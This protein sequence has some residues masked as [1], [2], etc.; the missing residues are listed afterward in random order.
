MKSLNSVTKLRS[1]GRQELKN[2]LAGSI[3]SK[4]IK[5]P[6][7]TS[8]QFKVFNDGDDNIGFTSKTLTFESR[9]MKISNI[10]LKFQF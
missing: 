2:I 10:Q 5:F 1:Q 3:D 9:C 4:K 7:A 6:F 8:I